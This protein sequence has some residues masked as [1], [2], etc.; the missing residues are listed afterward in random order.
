[1]LFFSAFLL[2]LGALGNCDLS[3][4]GV[5][6][7]LL[8]GSGGPFRY[9]SLSQLSSVTPEQAVAHLTGLWDV[10]SQLIPRP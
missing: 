5:D 4:A 9:T 10:K 2:K 1:M 8:T 7:I 6:K 3:A